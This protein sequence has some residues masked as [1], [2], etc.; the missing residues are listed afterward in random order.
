[1]STQQLDMWGK[2]A[3]QAERIVFTYGGLGI[4]VCSRSNESPSFTVCGPPRAP[5]PARASLLLNPLMQAEPG[6]T[7]PAAPSDLG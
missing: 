7:L 1:M 5:G 4:S 2:G 6:P 3:M